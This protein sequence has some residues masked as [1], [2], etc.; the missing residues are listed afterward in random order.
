MSET[1]SEA[2]DGAFSYYAD[3][4]A[5]AFDKAMRDLWGG[6]SSSSLSS[7]SP[8]HDNRSGGCHCDCESRRR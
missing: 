1:W 6:S 4:I 7:S 2:I 8:E 5:D 3:V